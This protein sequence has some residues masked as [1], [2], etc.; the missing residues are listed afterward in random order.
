MNISARCEYATRALIH[1]A[2]QNDPQKTISAITIAEKQHIPEKYLAHILLQLK[3]ASI[4]RSTRGAQGGYTLSRS[5][6]QISLLEIITA[7]DGPILDPLPVADKVS[8]QLEP[9][10]GDVAT[11]IGDVLKDLT[12]RQLMERA[13]PPFMYYI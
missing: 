6:D 10:W 1:L 11:G 2:A 4:V 5:P 9:I 12:L 3:R 8:H 7:I 13:G